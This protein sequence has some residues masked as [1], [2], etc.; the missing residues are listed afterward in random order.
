[1]SNAG[2]NVLF[3]G[4][5]WDGQRKVM[6]HLPERFYVDALIKVSADIDKE[7][8]KAKDGPIEAIKVQYAKLTGFGQVFYKSMPATDWRR[9]PTYELGVE[10]FKGYKNLA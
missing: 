7:T 1:M 5:P 2:T 6:D 3:V 8:G 9:F 10:L 4:G